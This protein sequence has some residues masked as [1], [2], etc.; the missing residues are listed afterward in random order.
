MTRRSQSALAGFLVAALLI[1][2]IMFPKKRKAESADHYYEFRLS[3]QH[4]EALIELLEGGSVPEATLR[5]IAQRLKA[6]ERYDCL[7]FK[8]NW[9]HYEAE[10][11]KRGES[12][13]DF[14]FDRAGRLAE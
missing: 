10:A 8:V 13:A 3:P 7:P 5:V 4:R 2:G 9:S 14:I 12:L 6:A 11:K 1:A